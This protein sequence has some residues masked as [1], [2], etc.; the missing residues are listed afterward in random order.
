MRQNGPALLVQVDAFDKAQIRMESSEAPTGESPMLELKLGI[1]IPIQSL[2]EAILHFQM[3][4]QDALS[5]QPLFGIAEARATTLSGPSSAQVPPCPEGL[6]EKSKSHSG[7]HNGAASSTQR[8]ESEPLEATRCA[9]PPPEAMDRELLTA[10][11]K[12]KPS[13]NSSSRSN[14]KGPKNSTSCAS[15]S[16]IS[17][18]AIPSSPTKE[19]STTQQRRLKSTALAAGGPSDLPMQPNEREQGTRP[20]FGIAASAARQE[21][22]DPILIF[23]NAMR[24]LQ[25]ERQDKGNV[26]EVTQLL[27]KALPGLEA[28]QGANGTDTSGCVRLLAICLTHMQHFSQ[29]EIL[30]RR[31][32]N[33]FLQVVGPDHFETLYSAKT[34]QQCLAAQNVSID[35]EILR[36][37]L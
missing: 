31:A 29:A 35:G 5:A 7:S 37:T 4:P 2:V 1:K 20:G 6:L 34:L 3:Q 17:A 16:C 32:L 8:K 11:F 18:A 26:S 21:M 30:A 22:E 9:A 33:G 10:N 13:I 28:A 25:G 27:W 24:L 12:F 15:S 19:P 14:N 36:L 23:K